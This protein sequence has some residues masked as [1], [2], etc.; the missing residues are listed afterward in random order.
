MSK[1]T[2]TDVISLSGLAS[3]GY[4]RER[5][6]PNYNDFL[7]MHLSDLYDSLK[8][9]LEGANGRWLDYGSNT[10]PYLE[11]F[12]NATVEC[13]D[14]RDVPGVQFIIPQTGPCPVADCSF[15][16]IL[17]TQVLE[18]VERVGESLRDCFRML[19]PGG[20]LVLTT[21]GTWDDH[22]CPFDYWRWTSDGLRLELERSGFVVESCSK[23]T[24]EARALLQL[25][26]MHHKSMLYQGR[27]SFVG[28]ALHLFA[29][30]LRDHRGRVNRYAD[31]FLGHY[32]NS[33]DA[34]AKIYL[35]LLAVARKPEV[36]HVSKSDL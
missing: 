31:R 28:M 20:K 8:D 19:K 22:G 34:E 24:T 5:S 35:A 30:I 10:S 14:I 26:I 3:E 7:Y 6:N 29:R 9:S 18:H 33:S 16:G 32:K 17:S 15:D 4:R 12:E 23:L 36:S 13:A 2:E 21:H 25:A 27:S 1:T 11:F